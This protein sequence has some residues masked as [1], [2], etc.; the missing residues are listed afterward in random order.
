MKLKVNNML[1]VKRSFWLLV[2]LHVVYLTLGLYYVFAGID[3]SY[4]PMLLCFGQL[5]ILAG[6]LLTSEETK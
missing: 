2:A 6:L 1:D 3:V 4:F 5:V